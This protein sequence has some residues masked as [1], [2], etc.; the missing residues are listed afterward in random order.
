MF[1]LLG[2]ALFLSVLILVG[3]GFTTSEK[4]MDVAVIGNDRKCFTTYYYT[5]WFELLVDDETISAIEFPFNLDGRVITGP[6]LDLLDELD[7][8]D[9]GAMTLPWGVNGNTIIITRNQDS[10]S[11]N[12]HEYR[13]AM[14][15]CDQGSISF[16]IKYLTDPEFSDSQEKQAT[17]YSYSRN[18]LSVRALFNNR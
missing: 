5:P 6:W 2:S 7:L 18:S 17:E 4:V 1:K 12:A 11:I 9:A 13:H 8:K 16:Y 14:Q 15:V 10:Q 3:A